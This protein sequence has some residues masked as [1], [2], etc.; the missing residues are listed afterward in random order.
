MYTTAEVPQALP[1]VITIISRSLA[2]DRETR[3]IRHCRSVTHYHHSPPHANAI[4]LLL[5][6]ELPERSLFTSEK[7]NS[8]VATF[9]VFTV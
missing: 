7:F 8:Q 9:S 1:L 3:R 5:I 2:W 4:A 6:N